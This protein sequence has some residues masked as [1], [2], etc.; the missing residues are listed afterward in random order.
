MPARLMVAGNFSI[1]ET[2]SPAG[3]MSTAPGGDALYSALGAAIWRCPVGILSRVGRDYPSQLW[4]QLR[5][6][7]V[8]VSGLVVDGE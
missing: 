3:A 1:D 5:S 6:W 4:D 2:I 7:G 8:D